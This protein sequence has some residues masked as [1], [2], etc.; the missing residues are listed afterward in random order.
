LKI[1]KIGVIIVERLPIYLLIIYFFDDAFVFSSRII[2][3]EKAEGKTDG[4]R[5]PL[6]YGWIA[7]VL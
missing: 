3:D 6:Q 7:G 4:H 1:F 5:P 2:L